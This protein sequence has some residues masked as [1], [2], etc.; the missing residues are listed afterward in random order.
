MI[1][2]RVI[3]LRNIEGPNAHEI[4]LR[5]I[6]SIHSEWKSK[7]SWLYMC[8]ACVIATAWDQIA[9]YTFYSFWMKVQRSWLYMGCACVIATWRLGLRTPL[10]SA[11][12]KEKKRTHQKNCLLHHELFVVW[13]DGVQEDIEPKWY[14]PPWCHDPERNRRNLVWFGTDS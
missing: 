10:V 8:C 3:R 5:S 11:N 13:L 4:R 6:H 7:R 9:F 1:K 2:T 14:Q 12:W